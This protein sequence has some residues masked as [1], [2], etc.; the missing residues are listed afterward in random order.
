MLT[1]TVDSNFRRRL[2]FKG[3]SG[4]FEG[5][6]MSTMSWSRP[7]S[8][9]RAAMTWSTS[10]RVTVPG[11]AKWSSTGAMVEIGRVV[12]DQDKE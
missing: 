9:C 6:G 10:T 12:A 2:Q 4:S 7:W 5:E 3:S 8:R 11:M 1:Q